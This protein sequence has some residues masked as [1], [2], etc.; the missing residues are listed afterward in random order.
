MASYYSALEMFVD[1]QS[2]EEFGAVNHA[3]CASVRKF[4]QDYLVMIAQLETQFLTNDTF[5]LHVLNIHILPTNQMMAQLHSLALELLKRNA[6]LDDDDEESSD[7]GDDFENI[8]ETLRE[9]GDL[10][11]GNMTGKKICKGG[12]VLGLI[13]KRLEAMSG[14][15]AARA[16][17]TSLLRDASRPYMVMLN[18]W[19]HHGGINDTHA[20][21]L[22]KEQK[23]IRRERLEQDY[24][25]E[26]WERRYTIREHDV[27]PQ[28]EGVKE[29]V[30]LAGKYLNVVRECGGVDVSKVV[31]D[32]P[33]SFDD[34]RFLE[35]VNIAYAHANESLMQL[36]L[37][38]HSLPLRLRSLK[39]YFFLDPSDYFSYFLE[40]GASELRKPVKSVNTG[41]LQSLLDLVLRQPGSIVSLDPFKEDVKVEMN[42]IT[43]TKSLQ[44][45][46]TTRTR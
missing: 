1:V 13:T 26:Y 30:L 12:V 15:P 29:K 46:T 39:H 16:L 3:L 37:T 7:S 25:D 24:T 17:L 41:K 35:N 33:L 9:G 36:L 22:V 5:T 19:L 38:T 32:V 31:K 45:V 10:G 2:R 6:L 44:R 4:L 42:E 43:L 21:F 27:P 23:S 28:L 40:L 11:A 8:L 20:E 14:D 34:S 18:E